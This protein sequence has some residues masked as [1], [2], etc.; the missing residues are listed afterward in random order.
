MNGCHHCVF[1][2]DEVEEAGELLRGY[3]V[4][5]A[6]GVAACKTERGGCRKD[7]RGEKICYFHLFVFDWLR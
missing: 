4:G 5:A 6:V 7:K 1:V 3:V 2:G